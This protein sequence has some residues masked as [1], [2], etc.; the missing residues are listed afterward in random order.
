MR[1]ESRERLTSLPGCGSA[2]LANSSGFVVPAQEARVAL[3]NANGSYVFTGYL[4]QAPQFE[5]LGW[6]ER[7][8]LYRYDLVAE[9]DEVLLDQKALP[10]RAPFVGRSAGA[11]LRQLAE[12]VFPGGFDTSAVQDVDMVASYQVNPQKKFSFHAAEI[13]L[14]ARASYRA[15]NG[16]LMLAPVGGAAYAVD[17]SDPT[18]SAMGLKLVCPTVAVNDVTV[19]GLDEPQAYVRDYFAGDGL[20]RSFYLSQ[21]PFQQNRTALINEQYVGTQLDRTTWKV[22]D[23][24]SAVSVGTQVLQVRGGTGQDGKTTVAFLEQMELGGA[25]ELQHGEVSFT[26]ASQG[27]IGGLYAGAISVPGC[28]AGFQVTP[29]GTGSKIQALLNGSLTGPAVA[30]TNWTPLR[31]DDIS[32]LHGNLPD[33]RDLS[34]VGA[35]GGERARR[36][37]CTGRRQIR[38]GIAGG[39]SGRSDHLGG[40][41]NRALR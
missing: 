8:L 24:G 23:P 17:E 10:N 6:G 37:F 12:D 31:S 15:M 7:G 5:C 1:L 29:N 25:V 26:G 39:R 9:S 34:L 18:F 38:P 32:L 14:A 20:S 40:T 33:T 3:T 27:V 30:T 35:S 13:A 19:I 21:K 28:L 11:A 36:I 16:S 22:T 41:G 4:T 2:S